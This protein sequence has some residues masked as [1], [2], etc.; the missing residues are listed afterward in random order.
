M[1]KKLLATQVLENNCS[2]RRTKKKY[3]TLSLE[4]EISHTTTAL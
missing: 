1:K 4:M 2:G 3:L